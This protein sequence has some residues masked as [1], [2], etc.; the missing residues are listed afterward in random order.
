MASR[1]PAGYTSVTPWII[2]RGASDLLAFLADVFGA[3][4]LGRVDGPGGLIGHAETRIG[5]AVVMVVDSREDWPATPTF[6][7]VYVDDVAGAVSRAMAAGATVVTEPTPLLYGDTVARVSDPWGNLWWLHEKT[8]GVEVTE[9]IRRMG[10]SATLEAMTAFED[11]LG[12][13]MRRRAQA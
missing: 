9:M 13:E 7:R 10:D 6:L 8:E 3:V 1:A 2:T 4:E 5:D 12:A 11:S